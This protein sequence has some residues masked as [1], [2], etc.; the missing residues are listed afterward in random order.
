[1]E[2][3]NQKRLDLLCYRRGIRTLVYA[4]DGTLLAL[5]NA[6]KNTKKILRDR[7]EKWLQDRPLSN[8]QGGLLSGLFLR[9]IFHQHSFTLETF[10][11]VTFLICNLLI[12]HQNR[13]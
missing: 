7:P 2:E 13:M 6:K 9:A 11:L 3:R 8:A 1:M 12:W 4:L 10:S 5:L